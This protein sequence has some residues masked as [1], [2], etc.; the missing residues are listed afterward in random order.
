MTKVSQLDWKRNGTMMLL[1]EKIQSP[2]SRWRIV[3]VGV[4]RMVFELPFKLKFDI[5]EMVETSDEI[6][7]TWIA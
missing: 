7:S 6:L 2:T 1:V 3:L 4:T 5:G